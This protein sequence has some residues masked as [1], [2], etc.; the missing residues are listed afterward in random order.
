MCKFKQESYLKEGGKELSQGYIQRYWGIKRQLR[1]TLK[2]IT[3]G[4]S[5]DLF[6][7]KNFDILY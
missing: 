4:K 3:E 5:I 7:V 1:H 2:T 6:L